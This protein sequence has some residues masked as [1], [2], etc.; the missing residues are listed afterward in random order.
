MKIVYVPLVLYLGGRAALEGRGFGFVVTVTVVSIVI[1]DLIPDLILRPYV[2]GRGLHTGTVMFAY[3]LGPVLFGWY[4]LF[5]GPLILVLVF[6]FARLVLP[7][8]LAGK[9]LEAGAI[10]PGAAEGD[11]PPDDE[12]EEGA[13]PADAASDD[14]G[15][16]EPDPSGGA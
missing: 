11:P 13:P 16:T 1:V 9:R 4:G 3:I 7:E 2:S 8:L 14:G 5:L 15:D 12:P 10:D 6:H